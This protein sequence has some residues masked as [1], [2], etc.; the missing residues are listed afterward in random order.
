MQKY[1]HIIESFTCILQVF[2]MIFFLPINLE[3][4]L[5]QSSQ[6]SFYYHHSHTKLSD[7]F[8]LIHH[9]LL[10]MAHTFILGKLFLE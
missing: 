3:Y 9:D 1:P 10:Y 5:H 8:L 6:D 2:V 7:D 4:I